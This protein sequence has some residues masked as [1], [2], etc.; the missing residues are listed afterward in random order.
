MIINELKKL[1]IDSR[2]FPVDECYIK[3]EYEDDILESKKGYL[4]LIE[5]D[6]NPDYIELKIMYPYICVNG[7]ESYGW[8]DI[9]GNPIDNYFNPVKGIYKEYITGYIKADINLVSQFWEACKQ[10]VKNNSLPDDFKLNF[11][12][13]IL[14][15]IF[16]AA[17][18]GNFPENECLV[19]NPNNMNLRVSKNWYWCLV[20]DKNT[21]NEFIIRKLKPYTCEVEE[22]ENQQ[23]AWIDH[24]EDFID[25][26]IR[27]I[28]AACWDKYVVAFSKHV[29]ND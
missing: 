14:G 12:E 5:N 23:Y 15:G 27:S 29:I 4:V 17:T 1:F 20:I 25:N 19:E 28:H 21:K 26:F 10:T 7:E 9:Y 22:C 6:C 11:L 8:N 2:N 18:E 13:E 3:S 24:K 16:M